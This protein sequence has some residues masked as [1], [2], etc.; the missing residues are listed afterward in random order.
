MNQTL[1]K[2]VVNLVELLASAGRPKQWVEER[3]AEMSLGV[4]ASLRDASLA[5]ID[6][7]GELFNL[8]NY[9]AIRKLRLDRNLV[10]LFQW[11]MELDSVARI[12][13]DGLPESFEAMS[14]LA[15]L[16][17]QRPPRPARGTRP[18]AGIRP[19]GAIRKK[20]A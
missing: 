12:A 4:V 10:E 11:G 2:P 17:I 8:D 5:V 15:R 20:T 19:G 7:R 1:K 6:A 9:Q 3:L 18:A 16:V 14:R 13:P